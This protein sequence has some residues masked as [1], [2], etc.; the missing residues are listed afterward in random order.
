MQ[1]R[2][3]CVKLRNYPNP[4][5][6]YLNFAE[7]TD[8]IR[9]LAEGFYTDGGDSMPEL[10]VMRLEGIMQDFY[11]AT[12]FRIG[13]IDCAMRER[14]SFPKERSPFCTL[15]RQNPELDEKC[16]QCDR[17]AF[18]KCADLQEPLIYPCHAGLMEVIV[19]VRDDDRILCYIMFGQIITAKDAEAQREKI[20][21]QFSEKGLDDQELRQAIG[22]IKC[23]TIE[24]INACATIAASLVLFISKNQMVK[25]DKMRFIEMLNAYIDSHMNQPIK[26]NDLCGYFYVSRSRLYDLSKPYLSCS[27]SEY[28]LRRRIR[29][30]QFLLKTTDVSIT[31]IAA[32]I[33]FADVNYFRR[34]FR[35]KTGCSAKEYRTSPQ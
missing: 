30:A 4:I 15:I 6:F 5:Q 23:R 1:N 32:R 27:L 24:Q 20:W 31:E 8:I 7:R 28:I 9:I 11:T 14:L 16:Q 12:H 10:N 26:I 18:L 25:P 17:D 2:P 21:H 33:G 22:K 34:V 3:I 29:H 19:P 35:Q 13:L